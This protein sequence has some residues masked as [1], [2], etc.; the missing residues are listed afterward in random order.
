MPNPLSSHSDIFAELNSLKID[1]LYEVL[2]VLK[3]GKTSRVEL[4]KDAEGSLFV[5]KYFEDAEG[6]GSQYACIAQLDAPGIPHIVVQYRIA[7]RAAV[8]M[9][10]VEGPTL[11][12]RVRDEGPLTLRECERLLQELCSTVGQL[13]SLSPTPLVH[14]DIKP[15][16]IICSPRGAI[17][18]DFG[19]ARRVRP[20]SSQDTHHWGTAGY[21]PPEQ[22]GFGQSDQRTDVYALGMVLSFALT[23]KDPQ[24]NLRATL[25][26]ERS[27]PRPLRSAIAHCIALDPKDRPASAEE[28][29]RELRAA[30]AACPDAGDAAKDAAGADAGA[31]T[32]TLSGK[33]DNPL[34]FYRRLIDANAW[35]PRGAVKAKLFR[36][37]VH[38]ATAATIAMLALALIVSLNALFIEP[39]LLDAF[40]F[41]VQYLG[42]A[43]LVIQPGYLAFTNMGNL[44]HRLPPRTSRILRFI[45]AVSI[46]FALFMA[47]GY[48][49][50]F[51]DQFFSTGHWTLVQ[52][53]P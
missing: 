8:V 15:D 9:E 19:I 38:T 28:L 52:Q 24:S 42:L 43:L 35:M 3:E 44:V 11:R 29:D 51:T 53:R 4:V 6:F 7:N 23:G 12:K 47:F 2:R 39:T 36:G 37:W 27:I 25:R 50:E 26:E 40:L 22:F 13:H 45:V 33:R 20:E 18:I 21:A 34:A 48:L 32:P 10:Y 14:R 5:R 49:V 16:N 17:L 46:L 1:G 41:I 30:F 31:S